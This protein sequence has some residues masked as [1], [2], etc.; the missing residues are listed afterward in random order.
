[1]WPLL[2][3]TVVVVVALILLR[4]SPELAK[5]EVLRGSVRLTRGR[6]PGRLLDD[7]EDILKDHAVG[8]A[9][10][11]IVVEDA[12]PRLLARGLGAAHEQ[13]LRNVLGPYSVSQIRA[14]QRTAARA[15]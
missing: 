5:L 2:A 6:L 12:R 3:L 14:G 8:N 15:R 1:M 13:Q 11:R 4:G 7:F 10:L 9:E